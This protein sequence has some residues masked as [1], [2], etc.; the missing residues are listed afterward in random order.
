MGATATRREQVQRG[1]RMCSEVGAGAARWEQV[2]LRWEQVQRGKRAGA[3]RCELTQ[4]V[5]S[6]FREERAGAARFG[7]KQQILKFQRKI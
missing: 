7:Q 4:R 3:A 5:R 1:S 2:P 6:R